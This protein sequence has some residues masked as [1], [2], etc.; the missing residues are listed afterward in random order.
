M[1]TVRIDGPG[2]IINVEEDVP[3]PAD[4]DVLVKVGA[5]GLCGTDIHI[6]QGEYLGEY[7]IVPGHEGAG[8]IESV[9]GKVSTFSPGDRVA[10]EPNISCD[11]CTNCLSNRQN[12]CLNWQ[13]VGVTLPG[14]M[15]EYVLVP[16]KNVFHIGNLSAETASFME[17][18]SCVIHGIQKAEIAIGDR[19]LIL[20]AGPIGN[21]LLQSVKNLG[22]MEIHVVD[23]QQTRL[24]IAEKSGAHKIEKSLKNVRRDFFDVVI[25]AT[26][27]V[28]VLE[29]C[30]DFVRL[31][32][33]MLFFGV[34]PQGI[35]MKIEPFRIFQKGLKIVSS[36]TSVRNSLQAVEMLK[37]GIIDVENLISHRLPLDELQEGIRLIEDGAENVQKVI[38]VPGG[39][40]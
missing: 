26:G 7:P 15:A 32:G 18:L 35:P 11:Y 14:A 34:A 5:C 29:M 3:T 1:K 22:A 39:I 19:V 12:F 4:N 6:F 17:P 10:F 21:L 27:S 8:E 38:M 2:Q 33:T 37:A 31:G 24:D 9:G 36:Y 25:D 16:S 40:K 23:K 13:A 20:G 28:E 30:I